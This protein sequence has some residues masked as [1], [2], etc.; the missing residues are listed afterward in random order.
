MVRWDK[1][2][3]GHPLKY[4]NPEGD[5]G[6]FGLGADSKKGLHSICKWK[7]EQTG[8]ADGPGGGDD[9]EESRMT[10]KC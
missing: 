5:G 10:L 2:E 8:F 1:A 9:R 6:D 3:G 7:V 4:N